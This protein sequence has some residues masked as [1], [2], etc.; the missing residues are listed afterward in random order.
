MLGF[1][2]LFRK[3]VPE[4]REKPDEDDVEEEEDE[5]EVKEEVE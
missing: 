1:K 5:V 2:V 3:P 4:V